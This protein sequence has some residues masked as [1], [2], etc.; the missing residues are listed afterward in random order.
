MERSFRTQVFQEGEN[1]TVRD[2]NEYRASESDRQIKDCSKQQI[3]K[4][5][6]KVHFPVSCTP[7][8]QQQFDRAVSILHSFGYPQGLQAFAEVTNTDPSCAMA[9]W[10]MAMSR[11]SEPA[12]LA[13]HLI[14]RPSELS[15]QKMS[16]DYPL[17][18]SQAAFSI[19]T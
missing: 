14:V 2:R 7:A 5:L 11:R 3:R 4:R 6:G 15:A 1:A 18:A 8:A 13:H 19:V 12:P 9:Y 17:C 16:L 10:G